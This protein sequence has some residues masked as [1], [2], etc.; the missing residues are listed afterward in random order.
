[1]EKSILKIRLEG[2]A[3]KLKSSRMK[4]MAVKITEQ[5]ANGAQ[6]RGQWHPI[7]FPFEGL[8]VCIRP[9]PFNVIPQIKNIVKKT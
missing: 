1:M 2:I 5:T 4:R 9:A 7:I 3:E 6:W 8:C